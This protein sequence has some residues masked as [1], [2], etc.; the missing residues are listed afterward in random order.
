MEVRVT[1][2]IR[3]GSL[4]YPSIMGKIFCVE[5]L[6]ARYKIDISKTKYFFQILDNFEGT[7]VSIQILVNK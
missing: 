1:E 3:A 2:H 5:E 7:L 4:G 6:G